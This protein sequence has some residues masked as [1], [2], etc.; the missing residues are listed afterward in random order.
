MA[1]T[2]TQAVRLLAELLEMDRSVRNRR[3]PLSLVQKQRRAAIARDLHLFALAKQRGQAPAGAEQ[4]QHPRANVRVKVQLLGGPHKV[5]LHSDSLA[6]GGVSVSV[7]FTPRVGDMVGL[8]LVPLEDPPIEVMG[9]VVWFD[10]VRS[11][12][13]LRFQNLSDEGRA[14]LERIIFTDLVRDE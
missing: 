12:A 10:P 4:R 2:A 6:V 14:V 9:E 11:R 1:I 5:D 7:K 3:Q 8:R 13:G